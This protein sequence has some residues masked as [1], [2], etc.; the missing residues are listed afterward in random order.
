[1]TEIAF[2][3]AGAT[4][5]AGILAAYALRLLPTVRLQ[6]AA[7][8][9]LAVALPLASVLASGWVMFHMPDD[10]K[11]LA[12]SSAAAL[13]AVV[14]ALLFGR[15]VVRP[16]ERL[17]QASG[18]LAGGDL[19]ARAVEEGP[20]ELSELGRA[21]NGMADSIERLFDARRQLVAW[22]SHDLRTPLAS[23]QAML[24]AVEDGLAQPEEYLPAIH[25]QLRILST[26][27]DDLFELTRI[28][29]GVLTLELRET[30]LAGLVEGC[31]RSLAA[32][33]R[34]KG[35]RLVTRWDAQPPHVRCAPEKV[36]RI[37][38]NLLANA[39]RHTPT[40][41][42]VAVVVDARPHAVTVAVEDS[43]SGLSDE[44]AERMFERFW[45]ADPAR[46]S[47]GSGLGLAIAQGLVEAQGGRIWAENRPEGG[48]RVAFTLQPA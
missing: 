9:F 35:V 34:S 24:E 4:L 44:T 13:S 22:A 21:F 2:V 7:L 31:V 12:V 29:A 11:I 32:D 19:G 3:L 37:L 8:A 15:W 1:M 17:R 46:G 28:D 26:L 18:E 10:A 6:L 23:A 5:I 27:V 41:G 43:G 39:L 33:A 40:D 48:A 16:I 14:G 36:E 30:A 20:R 25:D 38:H 42:S 47:N 45:R